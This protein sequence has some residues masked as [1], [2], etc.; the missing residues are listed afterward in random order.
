M[1]SKRWLKTFYAFK[2]FRSLF[3]RAHLVIVGQSSYL[4][5]CYWRFYFCTPIFYR[6]VWSM[7]ATPPDSPPPPHLEKC[8][9]SL[10]NLQNE[11]LD[12]SHLKALLT[13]C[14]CSIPRQEPLWCFCQAW[15]RSWLCWSNFRIIKDSVR[16]AQTGTQFESVIIS[17]LL[18]R[19]L[20]SS[21]G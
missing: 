9:V 3:K 2:F 20:S 10:F 17:Y 4:I 8:L 21:K 14:Y 18:R 12:L 11:S 16:K 15:E 13:F 5:S 19:K 6:R 1:N 7:N